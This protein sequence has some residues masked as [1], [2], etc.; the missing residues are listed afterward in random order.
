LPYKPFSRFGPS[1]GVDEVS[2]GFHRFAFQ[3]VNS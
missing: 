1:C 2:F 3:G